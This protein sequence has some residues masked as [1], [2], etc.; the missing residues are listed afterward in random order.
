MQKLLDV[1]YDEKPE[2]VVVYPT[3][4]MV[5]TECKEVEVE[6]TETGETSTKYQCTVERYGT[7]EYIGKL[8]QTIAEQDAQM[9]QTQIA[10]TE[11]Y[12][13]LL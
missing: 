13:M 1:M 8:Q 10:L 9:T 12:E 3:S 6:D 5:V 11:V 4:V 7:T 2:D